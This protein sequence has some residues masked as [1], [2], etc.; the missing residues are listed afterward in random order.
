MS[1][2]I[3]LAMLVALLLSMIA[4]G[5]GGVYYGKKLE[6]GEWT[7]REAKIN[8]DAAR[9]IDDAAKAAAAR[10]QAGAVAI[11]DVSAWYQGKLKEKDRAKDRAVSDALAGGLFVDAK[12]PSA[13]VGVPNAATPESGRDGGTRVRLSDEA[14]VFLVGEATR[15]DKIADQLSACQ[16]QLAID[17]RVC[18]AK[19]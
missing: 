3:R 7:E 12:C 18:N 16:L 11:A 13:A 9:Q 17:R 5:A 8:A 6:R 4:I 15:A 1:M 14:S 2:E 10:T 19:D